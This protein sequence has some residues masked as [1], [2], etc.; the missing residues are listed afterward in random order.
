[1]T[2][3]TPG[4]RKLPNG[5]YLAWFR[6]NAGKQHQQSFARKTRARDWRTDE[7]TKLKEGRWS[8]PK[9][10]RMTVAE[11]GARYIK[12]QRGHLKPKTVASYES[13]WR[14]R[15]EPRWGAVPLIA[16]LPSDVATWVA[17]LRS[18]GLSA[19]RTR[20]CVH[21][22]GAILKA[23]EADKR[24]VGNP[25]ASVKLPTLPKRERRYLDHDQLDQLANACTGYGLLVLVLGY[26]GLRYGEAAA[27]RVGRVD[28]MRRRLMI[29]E[30]MT[31]IGGRVIFGPPKTHHVREVPIPPFLV[32]RLMAQ[33][34]ARSDDEFVFA[35]PRGGVLRENDFR[36]R[37]FDDAC[38][39]VGLAQV[40]NRDGRRCY[41]GFTPHELRHTAASLAIASGA[42]IKV[43]QR[44]L[45]HKTATMTLDLYGHLY[46]DELDE[47]GERL[48]DARTASLSANADQ[49]R[50]RRR[51]TVIDLN[52][53][54]V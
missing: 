36:R 10:G 44:M 47:V 16:I 29:N 19:S 27:L 9:L 49:T 23:A 34:A 30:A 13:M 8:A 25:V 24:I 31:T 14:S 15:I 22:L 26:C 53:K 46:D 1:M 42:T 41:R 48:D 37:Y 3:P 38:V 50:A 39:A 4:V 51:P 54:A 43:V 40:V 21:L 18:V 20:Q 32:D 17:E 2:N 5:K 7:L 28:L 45:G 33:I 12:S 52:R 6:D 35:A 11:W